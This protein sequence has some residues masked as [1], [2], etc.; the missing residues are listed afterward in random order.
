M[1]HLF[2]ICL[3]HAFVSVHFCFMT[4][5]WKRA[6]LMAQF[7]MF[8]FCQF[9]MWYPGSGVVLFCIDS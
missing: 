4:P 1:D 9:P 5:C 8:V 7:M 3:V 6:D 2:D